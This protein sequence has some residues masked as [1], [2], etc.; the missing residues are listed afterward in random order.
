ML[1]LET[2][3]ASRHGASSP[4]EVEVLIVGYGPVGA[5]IAG[6]LGR[7]G[8]RTLVV[9][10]APGI[11]IA[12]RAI[13]L[14]NEALRILQMV[15]LGEDAFSRVSIPYVRMLSP[16]F[17]E[18]ARINTA[19]SIDGHPKLV[20]FYQP[21]LERALRV[22]VEGHPSVTALTGVEMVR[23]TE[24]PAGLSVVLRPRDGEEVVV[25][26]RYLIGADGAGSRVRAAIG[27]EFD[28]RT[29]PEDWLIVDALGVPGSFDHI[30]FLCRPER[31]TPHMVG[32]GGRTR[33]EFML[34]PGERREQMENDTAIAELLRPWAS[35]EQIQIERKAVYRFH[36]RACA[37]FSKG[38]V[39]LAGDAAH[40]TPPFAGQGLVAGLRDAANLSWKLA[41]VL[42]GRSSAAIL[43]S[44]D[45]ERRPH[46]SRMIALARFLGWLVTPRSRAR[47]FMVH[48]AMKLLRTLP[49]FRSLFDELGVK[50]SNT[51]SEGLFVPGRGRV[52]HGSWFPQGFVR[53]GTGT[54]AL[55]DDVLGPGFALV[56]LGADPRPFIRPET[57]REW[58]RAGGTTVEVGPRGHAG[59][60]GHES[61]DDAIVPRAGPVGWCAVVRPDR[62]VLHDGPVAEADRLL[63]ES[64]ANLG[65]SRDVPAALLEQRA[66]GLT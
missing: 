12:P 42:R 25:R 27:E 57:A 50:P 14:D 51:Y 41:W 40:L 33:W 58:A 45:Q 16:H 49:Q 10:R 26:T 53:D 47:A 30:E 66:S 3:E 1:T 44:Y 31:P 6:L 32:P 20:T 17:G 64:L 35:P 43:D 39:F 4:G 23:F 59:A 38:P 62:T 28:G 2:P 7:Y 8:V 29:Y 61:L 36:A 15:G 60:R 18:F 5:A 65:A 19:G 48:G 52:R 13:A 22:N 55:S 21:E 63:R 34:R 54:L 46:A 37:R 11:L 56:G 24:E 9:D